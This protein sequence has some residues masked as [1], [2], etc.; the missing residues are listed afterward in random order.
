MII[1]LKRHKPAKAPTYLL[2]QIKILSWIFFISMAVSYLFFDK[3]LA[4][5]LHQNQIPLKSLSKIFSIKVLLV[6]FPSLFFYFRCIVKKEKPANRMLFFGTALAVGNT[7][8]YLLKY[9]IGRARPEWLFQK[10]SEEFH[11]LSSASSLQSFPSGTACTVSICLCGLACFFPRFSYYLLCL[12]VVISLSR[13]FA[14]AHYLSDVLGGVY[15]G[16][17]IS[18]FVFRKMKEQKF[19]L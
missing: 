19:S 12:A 7:V 18:Q 4:A 15:L 1:P 10:I 9:L 8:T 5:I 2:S 3:P 6:A 13:V 14:E 11:P 16:M 17:V